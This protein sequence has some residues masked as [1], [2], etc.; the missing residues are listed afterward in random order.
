DC[1]NLKVS[2]GEVYRALEKSGVVAEFADTRYVV[3]I[4][5]VADTQGTLKLLTYYL[6]KIDLTNDIQQD[7]DV[8]NTDF[9]EGCFGEEVTK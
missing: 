2:G 1:S 4:F 3:C 8:V 5:G 7:K 9:T 6:K